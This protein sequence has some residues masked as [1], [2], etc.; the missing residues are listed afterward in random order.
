MFQA[1]NLLAD[2][3]AVSGSPVRAN[4]LFQKVTASLV[5]VVPNNQQIHYTT[6]FDTV[7]GK[8]QLFWRFPGD[9][10]SATLP[11]R[12]SASASMLENRGG[13]SGTSTPVF[14]IRIRNIEQLYE[15]AIKGMLLP[16]KCS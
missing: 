7:C 4:D 14:G 12:G 5:F 10:N 1:Q 6:T 9:F 8:L 2:T 11:Y 3:L 13:Q 16:L 15:P